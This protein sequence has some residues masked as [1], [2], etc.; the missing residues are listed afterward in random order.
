M[1]R[2]Q[3]ALIGDRNGGYRVPAIRGIDAQCVASATLE[4]EGEFGGNL[5]R[6]LLLERLVRTLNWFDVLRRKPV[7]D[8]AGNHGVVLRQI[9]G[10]FRSWVEVRRREV[11]AMDQL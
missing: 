4:S 10:G 3:V 2:D 5:C 1:D 11:A 8:G 7:F 9:E 6:L